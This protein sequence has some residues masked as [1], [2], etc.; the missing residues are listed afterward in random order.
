MAEGI[1]VRFAGEL[2]RFVQERV[3]AEGRRRSSRGRF[4]ALGCG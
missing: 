4:G 3:G 2:Q 1:N